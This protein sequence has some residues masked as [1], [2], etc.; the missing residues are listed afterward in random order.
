MTEQTVPRPTDSERLAGWAII[1]T[2]EHRLELAESLLRLALQARRVEA[3]E[4]LQAVHRPADPRIVEV[5][6]IGSTRPEEA[7]PPRLRVATYGPTG[8]GDADLKRETAELAE[9]AAAA[10]N[11][12]QVMQGPSTVD[13]RCVEQVLKGNV[14]KL[15]H[16][17]IWW[18]PGGVG[19]AS[20]PAT[21]AQW[22]HVDEALDADHRAVAFDG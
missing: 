1:A 21:L 8:N 22:V 2:Q 13:R 12:T 4:A 7:R 15:C 9:S 3:H 19:D 10:L 14:Y 5:P 6:F 16:G 18:R 11:A 17:A 20:S